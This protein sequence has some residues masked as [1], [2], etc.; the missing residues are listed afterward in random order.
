MCG[1]ELLIHSE[2]TNFRPHRVDTIN[3]RSFKGDREV[4]CSRY[5]IIAI[6]FVNRVRHG[7]FPTVSR[8]GTIGWLYLIILLRVMNPR[9]RYYSR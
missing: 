6:D 2:F 1:D 5:P 7:N 8:H 4:K 3:I 9:L